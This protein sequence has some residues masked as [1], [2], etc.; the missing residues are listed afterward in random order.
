MLHKEALPHLT[1]PANLSD[2]MFAPIS[3]LDMFTG[4]WPTE[5]ATKL[6]KHGVVSMKRALEVI[7]ARGSQT[8]SRLLTFYTFKN[9]LRP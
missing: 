3:N 5:I 4:S 8:F 6:R 2:H 1:F 9:Y 7:L